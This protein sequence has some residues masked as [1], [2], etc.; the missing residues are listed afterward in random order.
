MKATLNVTQHVSGGNVSRILKGIESE[1]LIN[2]DYWDT[3]V[4]RILKG[5]ESITAKTHGYVVCLM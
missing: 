3:M 1:V 5:I 4:G 2:H